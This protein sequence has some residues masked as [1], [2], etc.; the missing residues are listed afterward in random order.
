M[1]AT[2]PADGGAGG[3]GTEP[4]VAK[5]AEQNRILFSIVL[6]QFYHLFISSF[7]HLEHMFSRKRVNT[8]T[9]NKIYIDTFDFDNIQ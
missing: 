2:G 1:F 7:K 5:P 3:C 9:S 8:S 4:F 6:S